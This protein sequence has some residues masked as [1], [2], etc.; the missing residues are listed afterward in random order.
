M[1]YAF[2]KTTSK[3]V[4]NHEQTFSILNRALI[5]AWRSLA[6]ASCMFTVRLS[7]IAVEPMTEMLRLMRSG[8]WTIR[9]RV[10]AIESETLAISSLR[11][12]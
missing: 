12:S 2:V 11:V 4:V 7:S 8:D 5:L 1:S 3:V 6:L 9:E 10:R